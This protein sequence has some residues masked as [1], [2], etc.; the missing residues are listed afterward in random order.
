MSIASMMAQL[1]AAS[2]AIERAKE[3][4]VELRRQL[5]DRNREIADLRAEVLAKEAVIREMLV[6]S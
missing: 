3:E 6:R 5:Q 1:N 4:I 2:L